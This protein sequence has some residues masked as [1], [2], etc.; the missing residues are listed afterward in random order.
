LPFKIPNTL[1][2]LRVNVIPTDDSGVDVVLEA[3]DK[4]ATLAREH[5]F[6][7]ENLVE[8]VRK[9]DLPLIGSYEVLGKTT[10]T[11]N[12]AQIRAESH[13]SRKQLVLIMGMAKKQLE[14]Q[15]K[16]KGDAGAGK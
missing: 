6:E 13:V 1:K 16:L 15:G 8:A 10:F 3:E 12:G 11:S 4:D 7:L 9:V 5:A 2:W 14:A